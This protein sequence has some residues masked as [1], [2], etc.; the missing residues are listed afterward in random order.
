MA[1]DKKEKK[2]GGG[3]K[4]APSIMGVD[5]RKP[6]HSMDTNRPSKG[7][8]GQRDA[9]TVRVCWWACVFFSSSSPS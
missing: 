2:A 1:K 4:K 7:V 3:A 6:K 8:A 9:A 5:S